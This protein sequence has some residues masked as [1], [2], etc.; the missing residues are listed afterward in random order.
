MMPAASQPWQ[1]R[2]PRSATVI[3]QGEMPLRVPP[4]RPLTTSAVTVSLLKPARYHS[5]R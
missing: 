5:A 2:P 4:R 1:Q 3:R